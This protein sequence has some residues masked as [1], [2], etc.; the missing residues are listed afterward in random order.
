M[1]TPQKK[2]AATTFPPFCWRVKN[3]RVLI[4]EM[5]G[6]HQG[7]HATGLLRDPGR[8][9]H[10]V[11]EEKHRWKQP[12]QEEAHPEWWWNQTFLPKVLKK[13]W[14]DQNEVGA[15][16]LQK[17]MWEPRGHLKIP[18]R[19][20][21]AH[22]KW[23]KILWPKWG[24]PS[25]GKKIGNQG[26][27]FFYP[28]KV[29]EWQNCQDFSCFFWVLVQEVEG[30]CENDK[31][32]GQVCEF[33]VAH[34]RSGDRCPF[35]KTWPEKRRWPITDTP[36]HRLKTHM[37][38]VKLKV[39]GSLWKKKRVHHRK[40]QKLFISPPKKTDSNKNSGRSHLPPAG[41]GYQFSTSIH[42]DSH[43]SYLK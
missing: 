36:L 26:V 2:V 6:I 32:W 43:Y 15:E 33:Q 10:G 34:V 5:P 1:Y 13:F 7:R 31:V 38:P 35:R 29:T 11:E 27:T 4:P 25:P 24:Q 19:S 21:C 3:H 28:R 22:P 42:S 8:S 30:K 39:P 20:G 12:T 18:E 23:W 41:R 9:H 40:V 14:C 16:F 37:R 17:K